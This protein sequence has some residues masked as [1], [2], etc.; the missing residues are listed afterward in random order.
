[1]SGS[2]PSGR[3]VIT[4]AGAGGATWV[5]VPPAACVASVYAPADGGPP[6]VV[7]V[8]WAQGPA[9]Q[10]NDRPIAVGSGPLI[11]RGGI[12]GGVA[13]ITLKSDTPNTVVWV[14]YS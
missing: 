11:V 10:A 3:V 1:M 4:A 8:G 14:S 6:P 5:P 12:P 9:T 2:S 7:E 13:F